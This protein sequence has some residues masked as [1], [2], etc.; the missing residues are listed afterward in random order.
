MYRFYELERSAYLFYK[1]AGVFEG[2]ESLHKEITNWARSQYIG[3]VY[4]RLKNKRK[5]LTKDNPAENYHRIKELNP[6]ITELEK[7]V[8]TYNS[9]TELKIGIRGK[10]PLSL[11]KDWKYLSPDEKKITD[12]ILKSKNWPTNIEV[13]LYFKSDI[14]EKFNSY[15]EEDSKKIVMHLNPDIESIDDFFYRFLYIGEIS[16][17]EVAHLGQ[18]ALADIKN[19]KYTGNPTKIQKD[20]TNYYNKD[21]EF[22]P[23]LRGAIDRFNKLSKDLLHKED[24][25]FLFKD[26][27]GMT[28]EGDYF[29]EALKSEPEKYQKAVKLLYQGA[30][31]E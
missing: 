29:F 2:P 23:H 14:L 1:L 15:F 17:H 27:I 5:A 13:T 22:Y 24:I 3:Q 19:V 7:Y 18:M 26:F 25:K 11:I 21:V 4:A 6:L 10:F 12:K 31:W 28:D 9:P 30:Q 8:K 20:N 16:M